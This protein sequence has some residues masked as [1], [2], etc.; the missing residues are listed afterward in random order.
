MSKKHY[1]IPLFVPH[2]G[3]PHNCVFCNQ[4]RI[5]GED[6]RVTPESA[7][8]T[9]EEYLET[10]DYK[11]SIVEISFFGGT[12]TA[13]EENDQKELL[14][15]AK[16]YKDKDIIKFI[17]L[18]TRP[19]YINEYILDYLKKYGVDIIELGIQSLDKEVLKYSGRGHDEED[20]VKSSKLIKEYGFTL[21]HQLMIGLPKDTFHKDMESVSKSIK[22]NPDIARI[23]PALVIK[24]TPMEIMFKN[25]S[26]SPYSLE[27][28][29]EISQKVYEVYKNNGTHVIR[30]GL[31]PT[32]NITVGKDIVSG[33]FHPAFREL[34]ESKSIKDKILH[35]KEKLEED[36]T[37]EINDKDIS[38]LYANK[39][40]YFN[41]LKCFFR[42]IDV[43]VNNELKRGDFLIKSTSFQEILEI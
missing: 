34:V 6:E 12:F 5:T 20:V 40:V 1:I 38:K 17:R 36:I 18:S 2:E 19:D 4:S 21:G 9:I 7:A 32:D 28:A 23:Y 29:V 11:N 8:K 24:D 30:I 13:I 15:V 25:G 31:Q 3:C 27:E 26:Y 42:N 14:K 37:I 41:E 43:L 10:I 35:I 22:M 39:K 33:P 16:E